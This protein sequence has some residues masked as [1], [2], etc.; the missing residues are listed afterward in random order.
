MNKR[1][2]FTLIELL[3][4]ISIIALLMAILMP[5][6]AS[7]RKQARRTVC[8]TNLHNWGIALNAYS[9]DN[10][11]KLLSSYRPSLY[12]GPI[13]G[14]TF[15]VKQTGYHWT[16]NLYMGAITPYIP[17]FDLDKQEFS[18]AWI[19]PSGALDKTKL[20]NEWKSHMDQPAEQLQRIW[21]P[22]SYAYFAR[23]DQWGKYSTE[24]QE[25]TGRQLSSNKI[26]MADNIFRWH[27]D[28]SWWYNHGKTG[29]SVHDIRFG[30][31]VVIGEPQIIGNNQL[32][33]DGAVIWKSESE[34]DP[35]LMDRCDPDVRQTYS[36]GTTPNLG[37]DTTFW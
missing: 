2:A 8:S 25:L 22:T 17:G 28:G 24:P 3:V 23:A 10:N 14:I 29:G 37:A 27:V 15:L 21:F 1:R 6:L 34:F 18:P 16:N 20:F 36:S 35:E 4:V 19:C 31:N 9:A 12:N 30:K 7:V 33:G 5:A 11:G 32:F 26:V 13:P